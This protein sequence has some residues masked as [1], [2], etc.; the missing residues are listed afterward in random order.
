MQGGMAFSRRSLPALAHCNSTLTQNPER[1]V[2]HPE[3]QQVANIYASSCHPMLEFAGLHAA[4]CR[5]L[6]TQMLKF[7]QASNTK[8][9]TARAP[10]AERP[11][12]I[13]STSPRA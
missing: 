8:Q 3:F 12:C 2:E 13:K 1:A 7:A 11:H 9:S 5:T 10:S 6:L 4:L